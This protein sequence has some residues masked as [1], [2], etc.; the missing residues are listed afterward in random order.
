M[1]EPS[2]ELQGAI[3]ARLKADADVAAL[4]G[5]RIYD[6]VPPSAA[7][8]YIAWQSDQIIDDS[9]DCHDDVEV[10]TTLDIWA[11]QTDS[12]PTAA[13]VQAKRIAHAVRQSLNGADITLTDNAMVLIEH[14]TTRVLTDPD[15]I[16]THAVID[17]R[18]LIQA[19]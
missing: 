11:R 4:V 15:G 19:A 9:T 5:A 13:R 3:I 8:P 12:N 14:R 1:T 18:S 16:T 6:R 10:F 17:F 2:L 7:H